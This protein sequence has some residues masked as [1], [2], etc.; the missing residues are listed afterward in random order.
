[1]NTVPSLEPQEISVDTFLEKYAK[2]TEKEIPELQHRVA[3]AL[4][5]NE[6]DKEYWGPV[7]YQAQQDGF[8]PGGRINSAAGMAS[9]ST[10]INCFIQPVG[11]SVSG[12]DDDGYPSIYIAL[13]EAA[14]TMRRGGGV[15]YDFSRIRPF[16]AYVKGTQS[17]ASGP[18]SY[19]RVFDRSCETVESAGG[20]RGAQ[21]GVLRC[22]HPDIFSFITAKRT[23]GE[24][25]NFNLSIGVT[26]KFMKTVEEK[27]MWQLT[28]KAKPSPDYIKENN[29][30]FDEESGK[31]VWKTIAA[32]DLWGLV[33]KSTYDFAEPGILF[34]DRMNEENNLYYCEVIEA[35]NPCV[36]G[37]TVILTD[38]G[39]K[40]IDSLV[41]QEITVW[42]GFEWSVT[43]PKITGQNQEIIDF[44]FSDGSK[45]SCT[46]YHKFILNDGTRV[47][48][49]QLHA[50]MKLAKHQFPI[51]PGYTEIDTKIAYTQGFYS[52]DG[53]KDTNRIWLYEEKC[54]LM[55]Y[56]A[57]SGYSDQSTDRN[58][59]FMAS[60][61]HCPLPKN[62]V[63]GIEFSVNTRLD[64]LAGLFDSD[65]SISNDS[66]IQ[67]WSVD[68]DFLQNVKYLLNTLGV[69]GT[70]S[71]GNK[72]GTQSLPDGNGGWKE[73]ECQESWRLTISANNV[74]GL[75][76]IG[77]N[78]HRLTIGAIPN[79]ESSRFITITFKHKREH[80]EPYVYCFNE[81]KNH[82]GIFNGIMTAQCAEQPLPPYGCCDLGSV[83][84]TKFVRNPFTPEAFFD[85]E[86]FKN[87]VRVGIR[88]LDNVLDVTAWP[89]EKQRQEA[90]NKRRIGLGFMGIGDAIIMLNK[91]YNKADGVQFAEYVSCVMR[92]TAYRTSIDLAK[93][94][95]AF[96]FFD[97]EKYLAGKFVSR[98]PENIRE[99]IATYGIRNSHLLSIAPTGTI[100]IA[101]A[102][103]ASNG[104]EPPFSWVYDRKKRMADGSKKTFE[105]ADH[106]WRLY[107]AMGH[108]V[109]KLPDNFVTALE[110]TVEAHTDIMKAVQ[111][112]I[113]TSISKTVNI[114]ADYPYDQFKD[115]YMYAWKSGLKGLATYRPNSILGSVLSV[116]K[117]ETAVAPV[118]NEEYDNDNG[119]TLDQIIDEMYAQPFESRKDGMLPSITIKERFRTNEGEQKFLIIVSFMKIVRKTRF[120][121]IT[122]RRPVEFILEANFGVSSSSWDSAFRMMSVGARYGV[123][124]TKL[125]ENLREITW[126]HGSVRYGTK[127]K[128][129]KQVPLWHG[130]DA[131]AIGYIIE[132]ALIE[133]GF[134]TQDGKLA[135]KYTIA[136]DGN[137]SDAVEVPEVSTVSDTITVEVK[138][139]QDLAPTGRKCP[140]CGAH[141]LVK[142]DGC[143]QCENCG[144]KGS[145]G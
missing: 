61:N 105:V 130:S 128:D 74:M 70:I 135:K 38:Q 140:E 116:K 66:C 40:R 134:L 42:N 101:F 103:N 115:L 28:H 12:Y 17:H 18:L 145:C 96:P 46:P 104:I 111:P 77:L 58:K 114:P 45:L 53:Q 48:A 98:L 65:G 15:G 117:E 141:N 44:E 95:G 34:L 30:Y 90:M 23:E 109:K 143:D 100:A 3:I 88:M 35:T 59:R 43:V 113:D 139:D 124:V 56:L 75:I 20:R 87:V 39:Y 49:N 136:T 19:M 41:N 24:F 71:L 137:E 31:W 68:R 67:V 142:R 80:L 86:A 78:T 22:D 138:A 131:S 36:T 144:Y 62:F 33:M 94:K 1:M 132:A 119:K 60:M 6:A 13:G 52:G 51:I 125:I 9:E 97:K 55:P 84:L 47:E 92:D 118:V 126:E 14:E 79:R 76:D 16:H 73:Y 32:Q 69:T 108:D 8:V 63:P 99:D 10:L 37:D 112:F 120:G 2:G 26:D 110:M 29:S 4:A 129:G 11:D 82:S 133:D 85:E 83:N 50:G 57:L 102:D 21:M 54:N 91:W 123:P 25:N 106:A 93:E 122:I 72:K 7:F 121:T 64:W 107:R 81:E 5:S 127:L 27:G 89:L